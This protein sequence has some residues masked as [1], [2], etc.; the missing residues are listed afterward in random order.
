M[1]EMMA[2]EEQRMQRM[3]G[4]SEDHGMMDVYWLCFFVHPKH[5][6]VCIF[7]YYEHLHRAWSVAFW[8]IGKNSME[9]KTMRSS[10]PL[11]K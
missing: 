7:F 5:V 2:L 3:Q 8:K 6:G 9:S 11:Y 10:T 4:N 1:K